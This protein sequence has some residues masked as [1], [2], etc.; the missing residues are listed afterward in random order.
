MTDS[1]F[2]DVKI[3][4]LGDYRLHPENTPAGMAE[5]AFFLKLN[6]LTEAI[7]DGAFDSALDFAETPDPLR[8]YTEMIVESSLR[9]Q[10]NLL[11]R[12]LSRERAR[13]I[14]T[15][16]TPDGMQPSPDTPVAS[17]DHSI[18]PPEASPAL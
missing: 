17:P 14:A 11:Q 3:P 15:V 13:I 7:H 5:R 2:A 9:P 8:T 4:V 10:L 1:P 18:S 6:I 12:H 16:P